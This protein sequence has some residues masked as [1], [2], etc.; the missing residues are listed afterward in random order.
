MGG[1]LIHCLVEQMKVSPGMI[2]VFYLAN[3][4]VES[5]ND[6]PGIEFFAGNV[7]NEKDVEAACK[8]AQLVFHTIGSTTFDA[9]QKRLQWLVNVEGTRNVLEACRKS[10]AFEKLCYT[11]TVNVLAIPYPVGCAGNFDNCNPYSNEPRLH[12][13]SSRDETLAFIEHVKNSPSDNWENQIGIGYY[14]SK[15]AARN[16]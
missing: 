12:S 2:R 4:P 1:A 5:L 9:R 8:D 16:W 7:L 11:S 14:D 13:F 10:P 6:I 3:S 15:L